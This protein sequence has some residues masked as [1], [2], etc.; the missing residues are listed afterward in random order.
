MLSKEEYISN[1]YQALA[2]GFFKQNGSL[3][4]E[5]YIE[6]EY[7][8]YYKREIFRN[9]TAGDNPY[10]IVPYF[11]TAEIKLDKVINST[12]D[13]LTLSVKVG[14]LEGTLR[15]NADDVQK[16]VEGE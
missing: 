7:T 15:L 6:R 13:Y 1:N 4:K 9:C 2:I 10:E 12:K 5:Q 3:T 16:I 11:K 14:D 8:D